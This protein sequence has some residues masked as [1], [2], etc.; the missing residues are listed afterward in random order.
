M[1]L[2]NNEIKD[3]IELLE[4]YKKELKYT[5]QLCDDNVSAY[6]N[7]KMNPHANE[8]IERSKN[9]KSKCLNKIK[10]IENI[11]KKLS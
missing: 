6:S 5:A 8:K 11:V 4:E 7:Q 9:T 10:I 2:T 1:E 3:T